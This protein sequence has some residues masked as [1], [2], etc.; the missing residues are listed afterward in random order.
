MKECPHCNRCYEDSPRCCPHDGQALVET[1]PGGCLIDSKYHLDICIG[2]GGMGAVYRATHVHLRRLFAIKTI[3]PEFASRDPK[4]ADRF[5]Q[6]AR[7][8][9]AIQHP[10][11]VAITDFGITSSG[12]FY[13]VMEHIEGTTLRDELHSKGAMGAERIFRIFKQVIAGVAA[14]HRLHMVHRDLKPSNIMLTR[15]PSNTDSPV[16][17]PLNEEQSENNDNE[18]A[19]VVDFGLARFVNDS[20]AR[21]SELSDSGLVGSPLY[22]S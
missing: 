15:L 19:K 9:A 8:A 2:R 22:M 11:V 4:A 21:R 7:A 14:A 18:L 6:E 17:I 10:N 20:F 1:L 5:I 13:Y 12:L 3:L 16:I